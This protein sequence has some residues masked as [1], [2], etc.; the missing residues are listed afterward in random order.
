MMSSK[1]WRRAHAAS[2]AEV[3]EKVVIDEKVS[4]IAKASYCMITI[5]CTRTWQGSSCEPSAQP[6]S[7]LRGRAVLN[8]QQRRLKASRYQTEGCK[9]QE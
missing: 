1:A 4:L 5:W 8:C 3:P 2:F 9:M 7:I 6:V